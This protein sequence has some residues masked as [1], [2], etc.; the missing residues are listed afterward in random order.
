M[1]FRMYCD[2]WQKGFAEACNGDNV[3][4]KYFGYTNY[5]PT[6]YKFLQNLAKSKSII[7]EDPTDGLQAIEDYDFLAHCGCTG[8]YIIS[9]TDFRQFIEL[10]LNDLMDEQYEIRDSYIEFVDELT[11]LPGNKVIWWG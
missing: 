9:E 11:R 8:N 5:I 1:G 6:S 4:P 3:S 7:A 2:T 10:F